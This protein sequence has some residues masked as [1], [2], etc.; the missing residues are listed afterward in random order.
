MSGLERPEQ[1]PSKL[2]GHRPGQHSRQV[3]IQEVPEETN[4]SERLDRL[5][6]LLST[7]LSRTLGQEK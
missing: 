2:P 3:L 5:A 6:A 4:R 1:S 7:A